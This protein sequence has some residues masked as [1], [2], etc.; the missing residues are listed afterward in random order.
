MSDH[1]SAFPSPWANR[2]ADLRTIRIPASLP[3]HDGDMALLR[4]LADRIVE[5]RPQARRIT[6][7]P[8]DEWHYRNTIGRTDINP[9]QVLQYWPADVAGEL[10][11]Q[12]RSHR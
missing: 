6:M 2:F 4:E 5:C 1:I 9:H 3:E 8:S 10:L 11:R 7:P 12:W